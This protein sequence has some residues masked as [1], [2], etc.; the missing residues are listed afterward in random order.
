MS[1]NYPFTSIESRWQES[2]EKEGLFRFEGS[3]PRT[4][5]FN[6]MMFPYPSGHLHVGHGRNYIIG[7]VL[8][9]FKIMEGYKVLSPM[10]WDAFGL[11]AE[12]AAIKSG[13][14]P[15]KSTLENITYLKQQLQQWGCGYDWNREIASCHPG[16]YRWTQWLFLKFFEWGL[17]YRKKA[18]VN[19]CPSCATVLAN[20][21][22]NEGKCERC[23]STVEPRDL[24]Q[25]FFKI[26]DYAQR[27]L[28]DLKYL[29]KWPELV[30]VKQENWIGRSEGVEIEFKLEKTGERLPCFTT[31][32]DTLYG[33]TF[34]AIA[35]EHPM[36]E[37]LSQDNPREK[38]IREFVARAR[39]QS[40]IERA[41]AD[42][43]K[44]GI[45]TGH[46]VINPI[47]G[48]AVPLFV[49]NYVLMEYGTGAVMAV[50]AHDERDFAFAKKYK[51]PI[52]V[53][54]ESVGAAHA[55]PLQ[56]S[57]EAYVGDGI[58]TNSG[59]FN[60]L[61]NREAWTKIAE[62]LE[63]KKLGK[64]T[65]SF[66]IRDWLIS[67][68]RYWGAPIPIVYCE[69]CGT[70][71][72]PEK[73]LPVLLPE[74]ADFRPTGE[75]PLARNAEFVNTK[76]PKCSGPGKRETDTMDTFVDSAWYFLR[77]ISPREEKQ[78]FDA[79][80]VKRWMPVD[81]YIGGAE[82]ATK[83]LIYARFV[84]KVLNEQMNLGFAGA[85][86]EPF[87]SLFT[88]GL[89]CKNSYRCPRHGYLR[90]SELKDG[91]CAQC[92]EQPKI[93]LEKMSKS[94]YNTVDPQPLMEKYGVDTQRLY[95]LFIGP[96]D[97]DAVWE[98]RAVIGQFRFLNRIWDLVNAHVDSVRFYRE[99]KQAPEGAIPQLRRKTHTTVG[100]MTV[101]LREKFNFNKSIAELF[102]W[103]TEMEE[104]AKQSSDPAMRYALGEA[105]EKFVLVSSP[106][107]PHLCEELWQKQL[108]QQN[109][110]FRQKWPSFDPALAAADQIEVV[111]QVNGKLRG[112][113][114]VPA[115]AQR[116]EL[117]KLALADANVQSHIGAKTIAKL[118]VV[119]GKLV[120]VVVK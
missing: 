102:E 18:P 17:A 85:Q 87:A 58:Q 112:K 27:L 48:E 63:S 92:G 118:I 114:T 12:N 9:R 39:K 57:E 44:E 86:T 82:H 71:P 25:W 72:V 81:Q 16:Y 6:L 59:T 108:A 43:A 115:G 36:V 120:N 69:K 60:G 95:T 51:L 54:I 37:K 22:V 67:R 61:S 19:W 116:E 101:A 20:E 73:D 97:K 26:T 13:I 7:D 38:E 42:N 76:C 83:H 110:I 107:V 88:Q 109:S 96:P 64:R 94:H 113:I 11:P 78:A 23:D 35:P 106:L 117:E 104:A 29:D 79:A 3:D 1:E 74:H 15:R 68:Q 10:G 31:R 98:D 89:I 40:A 53:V 5:F 28:D 32:V 46:R 8:T 100:T 93:Q 91:K 90:E 111:F 62:H 2:W 34:M 84:Y 50:P 75:S 119:P 30:R 49:T 41:S 33:V 24:A 65:I 52:R 47:N 105:I 70:V 66:R 99:Q 80:E 55:P 56:Q 103:L 77:F 4:K 21:Q 45:D 14:H